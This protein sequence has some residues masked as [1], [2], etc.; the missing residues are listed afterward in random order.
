[1]VVLFLFVVAGLSLTAESSDKTW[2]RDMTKGLLGKGNSDV[3]V[4]DY[5]E[6]ATGLKAPGNARLVGAQLAYLLKYILKGRKIQDRYVHIIGFSL[7]AH[8]AGYAGTRV[9]TDGYKLGR[10]TGLDPGDLPYGTRIYEGAHPFVRLDRTDADFV[11]V[12]HTDIKG[13]GI[14]APIGHLDF[15]PNGGATQPGCGVVNF[16]NEIGNIRSRE[17]FFQTV[18]CH[19]IRAVQYFIESLSATSCNFTAYPCESFEALQDGRC[20]KTC[21]KGGCPV[22]GYNA[23]KYREMSHLKGKKLYLQTN[24]KA[25]FCNSKVEVAKTNIFAAFFEKL[26][27]ASPW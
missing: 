11:D 17:K 2:V 26:F 22:M 25:P 19:H 15:F 16:F 18:G 14:D 12:I 3:I 5:G 23:M 27:S 21:G 13:L 7:G 20:G 6:G 24:S 9:K 8:V 10:I 1:M 4:M